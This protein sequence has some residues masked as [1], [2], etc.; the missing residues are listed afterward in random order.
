MLL[1]NMINGCSPSTPS[2]MS[3]KIFVCVHLCFLL[4]HAPLSLTGTPW[5]GSPQ[6]HSSQSTPGKCGELCRARSSSADIRGRDPME[7][8]RTKGVVVSWEDLVN[9]FNEYGSCSAN[10]SQYVLHQFML[11]YTPICFYQE[12]SRVKFKNVFIAGKS[13]IL[14]GRI[15]IDP[16]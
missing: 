16:F 7:T 3:C 8:L 12:H 9:L 6:R 14:H 4:L 5:V 15:Y 10:D 13:F 2:F 1:L 11:C